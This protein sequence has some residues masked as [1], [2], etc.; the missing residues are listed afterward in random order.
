MSP[1]FYFLEFFISKNPCSEF[2]EPM[3]ESACSEQV[4]L[5]FFLMKRGFLVSNWLFK[6]NVENKSL[7]LKKN[8]LEEIAE[9][10]LF[11]EEQIEEY[12]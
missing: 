1:F 10:A 11:S 4:C 9:D 6:M 7:G 12:L 3:L 2:V 8:L 5:D